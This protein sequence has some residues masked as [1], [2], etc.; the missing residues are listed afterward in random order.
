MGGVLKYDLSEFVQ[1]AE[2]SE[3][4]GCGC[5]TVLLGEEGDFHL[6]A[7]DS[8]KNDYELKETAYMMYK[9]V[10]SVV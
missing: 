4:P 8:E 5:K 9:G 7:S 10:I 2:I 6:D 3:C 1:K